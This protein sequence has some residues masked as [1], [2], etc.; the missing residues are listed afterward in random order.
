MRGDDEADV[1]TTGIEND[2]VR[3]FGARGFGDVCEENGGENF[4]PFD[5]RARE[6]KGASRRGVCESMG[7]FVTIAGRGDE[8]LGGQIWCGGEQWTDR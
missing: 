2:A 3:G 1:R 8:G 6:A 7:A 5:A 4:V